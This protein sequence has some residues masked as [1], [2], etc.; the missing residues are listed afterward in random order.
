MNKK[1]FLGGLAI[2]LA[3]ILAVG[4]LGW[5]TEGFRKWKKD[6]TP[7][8]D[9]PITDSTTSDEAGAYDENGNN[10]ADGKV[11]NMPLSLTFTGVKAT[12]STTSNDIT[13]NED[14]T[15]EAP[16][17]ATL[18]TISRIKAALNQDSRG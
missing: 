13:T 15:K 14:G 2:G 1:S 4:A 3:G 17:A 5:F 16:D 7:V 10:L 8:I 11:H 9:D 6:E 18:Q 12:A